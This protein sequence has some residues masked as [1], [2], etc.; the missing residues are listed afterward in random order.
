[1][2]FV[3]TV[4]EILEQW[5]RV[6]PDLNCAPMAVVGRLTRVCALVNS[7]LAA[8]HGRFGL[9]R[10]SFDVLFTLART[11]GPYTLSPG[12]LAEATMVTSAAIAQRL[13]KL[14]T[15]GLVARAPDD[16]DGRGTLVSLTSTGHAL[17]DRALPAHLQAEEDFLAPLSRADRD[18][19]MILLD[20]L[21]GSGAGK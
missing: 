3:L 4:D 15:A 6:R 17:V 1:M 16:R 11:G 7:A 2:S 13:N 12:D 8:D 21:L 9:D 5:Q 14:E 10:G 18:Q 20:R 19:L